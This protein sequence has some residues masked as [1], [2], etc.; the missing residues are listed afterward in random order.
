VLSNKALLSNTE[1]LPNI[2]I[3]ELDCLHI[4]RTTPARCMFS[5]IAPGYKKKI[6]AIFYVN[7]S[8]HTTKPF[9]KRILI[10]YIL[11]PPKKRDNKDRRAT[12]RLTME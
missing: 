10:I 3:N 9:P 12:N 11:S 2:N 7:F 4:L 1:E 5:S 6:Y 8:S